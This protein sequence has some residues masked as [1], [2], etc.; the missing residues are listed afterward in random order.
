MLFVYEFMRVEVASSPSITRC[1]TMRSANFAWRCKT[2]QVQKS[3]VAIGAVIRQTK[4]ICIVEIFLRGSRPF[5]PSNTS[6][7]EDCISPLFSRQQ[8]R[9]LRL[10]P[11]EHV[12]FSSFLGQATS[13]LTA[14]FRYGSMIE[15]KLSCG[16]HYAIVSRPLVRALLHCQ[17]GLRSS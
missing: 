10:S 1:S 9:L 11:L 12:Y 15:L 16:S 3:K 5:Y 14:N 6:V 13:L 4:T 17:D 2:A 7:W 8:L